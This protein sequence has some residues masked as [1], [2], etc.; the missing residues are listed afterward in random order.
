MRVC[1][2]TGPC[3]FN[4]ANLLQV[5]RS[6]DTLVQTTVILLL[7]LV[8]ELLA[9]VSAVRILLDVPASDKYKNTDAHR[10]TLGA[11]RAALVVLVLY[12]ALL[13][14]DK[15]VPG[16]FAL[17]CVLAAAAVLLTCAETLAELVPEELRA[18]IAAQLNTPLLAVSTR[19]AHLSATKK[20][21]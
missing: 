8:L 9:T 18:S 19:R 17:H 3:R 2:E 10:I 1:D 7:A 16:T 4:T 12:T 21:L 11:A 13:Q 20:Q 14:G 6:D 15:Y 5:A